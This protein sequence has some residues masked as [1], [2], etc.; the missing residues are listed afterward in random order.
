MNDSINASEQKYPK[1]KANAMTL[2][3]GEDQLSNGNYSAGGSRYVV[4]IKNPH[5]FYGVG[6]GESG[7]LNDSASQGSIGY[8]QKRTA[9][10]D[11][12]ARVV[13]RGGRF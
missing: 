8:S 2:D 11:K 13:G 12:G 3:A 5:G 10:A 7:A 1:N 6:A 9:T 4:G